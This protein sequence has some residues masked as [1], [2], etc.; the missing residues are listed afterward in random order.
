MIT[1]TEYEKM[2]L[3]V[4]KELQQFHEMNGGVGPHGFKLS[5]DECGARH[6]CEFATDP[7]NINGD[8]LADK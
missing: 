8:C 7:Y 6:T 1:Q 2:A 5:C 3:E 4:Y